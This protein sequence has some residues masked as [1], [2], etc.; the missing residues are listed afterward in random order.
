[1]EPKEQE[2]RG[3]PTRHSVWSEDGRDIYVQFP[4]G[5][6]HVPPEHKDFEIW[7]ARLAGP[8]KRIQPGNLLKPGEE[9]S[10]P[11]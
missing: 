4:D 6:L 1:M 5:I 8:D 7:S 2:R 11:G 10:E 9:T 3:A